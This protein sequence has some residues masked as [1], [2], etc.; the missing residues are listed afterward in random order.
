M[1]R[2]FSSTARAIAK[3]HEHETV[4]LVTHGY[5]MS[6]LLQALVPSQYLTSSPY[7]AITHLRESPK[8][9]FSPDRI[10]DPTHWNTRKGHKHSKYY[11][12]GL[13]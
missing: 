6:H 9:V 2:R 13:S 5:G 7:C 10:A 3:N 12:Q 11:I 1:V 4:I 8:G